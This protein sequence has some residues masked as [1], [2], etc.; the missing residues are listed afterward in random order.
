MPAGSK[1]SPHTSPWPQLDELLRELE[2]IA[3]SQPG[4]VEP[5]LTEATLAVSKATTALTRAAGS[6]AGRD[7]DAALGRAMEMVEAARL[8]IAQ[9]RLAIAASA[10]R[11]EE[12]TRAR[13][14]HPP[15]Q[16]ALA[17]VEGDVE[18]SCPS[19]GRGFVVRYRSTG[20]HPVVAFPIACPSPG[21]EGLSQVEYPVT[22]FSVDVRLLP[23]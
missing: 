14:E 16:H 20:P 8:A 19:C 17:A 2:E 11:R 6:R 21:C 7:A 4:G 1:M 12:R 3:T 5:T 18:G 13:V 15:V 10:A 23:N 22:A 9:A